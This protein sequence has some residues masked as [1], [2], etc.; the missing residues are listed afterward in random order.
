MTKIAF[1]FL[2]I[3]NIN[4][5]I[6]WENYFKDNYDKINIYCHPK[7]PKN[8]TIPWLK[9]N[10]INNLAETGWGYIVNAYI[11]LL[12]AALADKD[13]TKFITISESCIPLIPFH[14]IY[15]ILMKDEKK[16]F[17][18]FIKISRYDLESRIK[19]QEGYKKY[20]FFKH[21]ARFCL[22]RHH[23]KILLS[24]KNE[25]PFFYKMHVGDEFFLSLLYPFNN[26]D[27][28]A[29]TYDNW[30]YVNKIVDNINKNIKQLYIKIETNKSKNIE[31]IRKE[32][33]SAL[34][35]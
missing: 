32:I 6:M 14:V 24:K 23:T 8:V 34:K 30:E 19:N 15:E 3:D 28:F 20:K 25:L 29:I 5:P 10:I 1:L 4:H 12:Y 27:D 17:I 11:N 9:T 7:N 31:S 2:T 33:N 16:S 21:Y 26:I 35:R 18:K 13:N 22:S